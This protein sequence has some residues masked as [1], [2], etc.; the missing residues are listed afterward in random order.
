MREE[1]LVFQGLT[2]RVIQL[3]LDLERSIGQ[4]A[5]LLKELDHLVDHL[6]EVHHRFST[7]AK[8][9]SVSGSQN[10]ISI[11]RYISIAVDSAA[12]ACSD[13]PA[14]R[15]SLPRPRWQWA[16]RGRM[17]SSSARARAWR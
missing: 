16:W 5:S 7:S 11:A 10:V 14:R 13:W 1:Q 4:P 6:I 2:G 17:P 3:E 8:A 9:A 15:Y 12:W